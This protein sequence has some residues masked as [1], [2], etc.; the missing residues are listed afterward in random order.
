MSIFQTSC[1]HVLGR[2]R[3]APVTA[4]QPLAA[5]PPQLPLTAA[6]PPPL[7]AA[8]PPPLTAAPPDLTPIKMSL[9]IEDSKSEYNKLL[10][11][12]FNN[13]QAGAL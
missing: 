3:R 5:L 4:M 9:A 11:L 12:K 8:P 13:R 1:E 2:R 7:T 6:P 10:I